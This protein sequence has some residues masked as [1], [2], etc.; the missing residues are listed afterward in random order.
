MSKITEKEVM[1]YLSEVID[2]EIGV[3]IVKLGM[4]RK[5]SIDNNNNVSVD[6]ALTVP[7]CPLSA[8]IEHDVKKALSKNKNVKSVKVEMGSMTEKERK[9]LI[10]KLNNKPKYVNDYY[11]SQGKSSNL[12]FSL[13]GKGNFQQDIKHVIPVGS[14]KGGVGKSSATSLLAIQLAKSGYKVGIMDADITGSSIAKIFGVSGPLLVNEQQRIMP[15]T[16]SKYKIKM[17]ST[18]MILEKEDQPVI[19]RGPIL[20]QLV[21]Q[22]FNDVEWGS[23]DFLLLDMPPGTSDVPLTVFQNL[24]LTGMIFVKTPQ[25]LAGVIV[26]KTIN[27]AKMMNIKTIGIIEN[28]KYIKCPHC[29]EKIYLWGKGNYHYD[30]PLLGEVPIQPD[31]ANYMDNGKVEEYPDISFM[32]PIADNLLEIIKKFS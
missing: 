31:L 23:L 16:S 30:I 19:W 8:T 4:V 5:V 11:T 24:P 25:D 29:G 9:E 6:I 21:K 3:S 15:P 32:K 22:F 10:D 1:D 26:N 14:G 2:P 28:M 7:T 12:T 20:T 27:M 18:N 17:V 13:D